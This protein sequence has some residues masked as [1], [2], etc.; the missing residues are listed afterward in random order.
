MP[1]KSVTDWMILPK[2]LPTVSSPGINFN[3]NVLNSFQFATNNPTAT[4]AAP[5][6][7]AIIAPRKV[8][9]ALVTLPTTN[10]PKSAKS[11]L[12]SIIELS[13]WLKAIAPCTFTKV[14]CR[15][16]LSAPNKAIAP[17][18]ALNPPAKPPIV[19]TNGAN[20]F[21]G[22]AFS[23]A[24]LTPLICSLNCPALAAACL[25]ASLFESSVPNCLVRS[26][27]SPFNPFIEL[28][29]C[30]VFTSVS[31]IIFSVSAML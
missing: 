30:P 23:I 17:C 10:L 9:N 2:N 22:S 8:L 4:A 26:L 31:N 20:F 6:P 15:S 24:S 29:L 1:T 14:F 16:S 3:T 18:T 12:N 13:P 21:S 5:I 25:N 7:V 11:F 27:N 19:L 28:A